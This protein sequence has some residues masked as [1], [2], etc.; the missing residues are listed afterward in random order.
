MRITEKEIDKI[1]KSSI[2]HLEASLADIDKYEKSLIDDFNKSMSQIF[3]EHLP[4]ILEELS[5]SPNIKNVKTRTLL[6][7]GKDKFVVPENILQNF[8]KSYIQDIELRQIF[9]EKVK[10][11][12]HDKTEQLKLAIKDVDSYIDLMKVSNPAFALASLALSTFHKRPNMILRDVQKMTGLAISEGDIAELAAGEGKTLS[13]VLPAFLQSLRGKGVHVI[14]SN[15]YLSKRDYEETLPIYEGLGVSSGY[16][17]DSEEELADLEGKKYENLDSSSRLELQKRLKTVKQEAYK[18]DITYGSKDSF[19]FDYLRDNL[20]RKQEDLLQRVEKPGFALID[21]IDDTLID[22]AQT[23]YRIAVK[24]PMYKYN[25]SLKELCLIQGISYEET[26]PKVSNYI[27]DIDKLTYEEARYVSNAFGNYDLLADVSKYQEAA[28]R[29]FGLQKIFVA[30]DNKLGFKT[31]KELYE[32]L[33]DDYL[34]DAVKIRTEYGILFCKELQEF[35]ISDKC[36]EDFLKY[37]YFS[38]QINSQI[39]KYKDQILKDSNYKEK[40]DYYKTDDGK[41]RLTTHGANKI[42]NDDNYPDFIEDYNKYLTTIAKES[43][44]VIHYFRQAVIAHLLMKNGQD[45]IVDNGSIKTLKNG[46]IQDGTTYSNGLHQAIEI[47]EKIPVEKRTKE[48]TASSTITQ[49]DFYS[50]YD[51]FSGMTGTSSKSVFGEIFGKGTVEIPRHA[52]YSFY[53]SRKIPNAKEP[54]GVDKRETKFSI[55]RN[56]KINAIIKSV[57]ESQYANPKQPVLL[58]VSDTDEIKLLE[59]A[60]KEKS[61]SFNTLT[62]TTSKED[63][64][65][66]IAKAGLPGAVTISTIMSGRG[67]DI[68]VG[69]DR[70]TIIDIATSRHIK[71][72]EKKSKTPL[73]LSTTEKEF[74]RKKVENA[75]KD[76][77]WSKEEETKNIEELS[78]IGLKVISSGFF[79]IKRMDRQLEGRTGRN[80]ISGVCERFACPDDL[81]A[82]G[83]T[84]LVPNQSMDTY[85][86]S[87]NKNQDLTLQL[88]QNAYAA[89]TNRIESIQK[90]NEKVIKEQIKESQKLNSY[91]TKLVEEY[92]DKR[93]KIVCKESQTEPLIQQMIEEATNA[94]ISSYIIDNKITEQNLTEPLNKNGISVDV[95][96]ISLEVKQTLGISFDPNIVEKSNINLLELRGAIIRTAKERRKDLGKEEDNNILLLQNDYMIANIPEILEHSFAVKNL[97]SISVGLENQKEALSNLEFAD[98]RKQ[99]LYESYKYALQRTMGL[100]L[101]KKEFTKLQQRKNALF[102]M[103]V[104]RDKERKSFEVKAAKR[105]ENQVAVVDKLIAIKNKIAKEQEEKKQELIKKTMPIKHSPVIDKLL[106]IKKKRE[107]GIEQTNNI[108][109]VKLANFYKNLSVRPMKFKT[110]IENGLKTT[111]LVL[112]KEDLIKKESVKK[113]SL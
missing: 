9:E 44:T 10:I 61:I 29:F 62:A 63:E 25:M 70:N 2:K 78:S 69:G 101:D 60:L 34:Y 19:A 53:S 35:K 59:N 50:R 11:W 24:T 26:L 92:R 3:R 23:P 103:I 48:T 15:G 87:F 17:P 56:D 16:V 80:G 40:E 111:K 67:T 75:I 41:I 104:S 13:A 98:S 110:I 81:K 38:F 12:F 77:I 109:S 79:P 30:E 100:P 46:R 33:L 32:A 58:V 106:V 97:V 102:G 8:H 20:V 57:V 54:I 88:D 64:A 112:V 83:V 91:A 22:D 105:K 96:A 85:L 90:N 7:D 99:L 93:R 82:I 86:G 47:K 107:N 39:I 108:S 68:I 14:T 72:L 113:A 6:M 36:L 21:E 43:A 18:K 28:E 73:N 27:L 89:I 74:L 94:I 95:E 66:I 65:L 49:K 84:S 51:L 71:L 37:C 5:K 42:L 4:E 55:N 76:E 1:N 45:Y 31:G 52:F